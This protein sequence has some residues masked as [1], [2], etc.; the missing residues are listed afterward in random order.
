VRKV[1]TFHE[2]YATITLNFK[3]KLSSEKM[4]REAKVRFEIG[5]CVL[6]P[7]VVLFLSAQKKLHPMYGE[8]LK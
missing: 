2:D 8:K 7:R 4:R 5:S 3:K 6:I 1:S